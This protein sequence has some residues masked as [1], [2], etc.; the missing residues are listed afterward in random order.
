[1]ARIARVL[2]TSG[3]PKLRIPGKAPFVHPAV[4]SPERVWERTGN[5]LPDGTPTWSSRDWAK[6]ER[7]E[8]VRNVISRKPFPGEA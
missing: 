4:P 1:M 3:T 7:T 2:P 5:Y 6:G 8:Y